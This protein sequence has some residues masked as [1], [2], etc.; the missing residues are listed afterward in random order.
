MKLRLTGLISTVAAATLLAGCAAGGANTTPLPE[1]RA[2]NVV[3]IYVTSLAFSD[4]TIYGVIQGDRRRLGQVTGKREI[5]FT[6]PLLFPSEM[7]LEIDFLAGPTCYTE[8]MIV[9][10][11]DHLELIIQSE[12]RSLNCRDS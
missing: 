8:R 12:N 3:R 5:V 10:P 1:D 2:E 4:A 7:Y 11:G 6:M 9:D